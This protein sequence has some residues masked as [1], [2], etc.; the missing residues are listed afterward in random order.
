MKVDI[1]GA[2]ALGLLFGG[3]LAAGGVQ[4]RFWTRTTEQ[5]RLLMEE[6]VN[7]EEP[8]SA[9]LHIAPSMILTHSV[10]DIVDGSM[11]ISEEEVPDWIFVTTKQR[12][13]DHDLLEII[14]QIAGPK[15]GIVCFQNGIGHIE[16]FRSAFKNR[17]IYVAITTEGAK[18]RDSHYVIRAGVG[19]TQIGIPQASQSLLYNESIDK[20]KDQFNGED[21][22]KML[23]SAGF[24]AFLSKEIDRDIYRKLLINAVINP[25]TAIWRIPNGELLDTELR[26]AM[27]KQLCE[28]GMRIYE[29]HQISIPSNM[30]EQIISVCQSTAGN[31]SSM[32]SDVLKGA[33]TEIDSINGRLTEMAQAAGIS[34]PGHETLLNLVRGLEAAGD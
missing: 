23:E 18:R 7:I 9:L 14:G 12:S 28:E 10:N 26:V 34:A 22:L 21:L 15:T 13:V 11:N 16:M 25:L 24:E 1:I 3:K 19:S 17:N 20:K 27:L 31:I 5:A 33:P 32:L 2:G 29:A 6:G 4:V 8:N 30:Y